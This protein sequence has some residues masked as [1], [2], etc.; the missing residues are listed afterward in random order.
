MKCVRP[1][2]AA[3]IVAIVAVAMTV[4][5]I[6]YAG[7]DSVVP[8][9]QSLG[10]KVLP[11]F[12]GYGER[13]GWHDGSYGFFADSPRYYAGERGPG[14]FILS[15]NETRIDQYGNRIVPHSSR[16]GQIRETLE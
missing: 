13:G 6:V 2:L 8:T 15:P 14:S 4:P 1:I 3:G 5:S 11:V 12:S 16:E 7:S 9:F 10:V